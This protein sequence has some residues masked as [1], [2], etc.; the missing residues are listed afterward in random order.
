MKTM[1]RVFTAGDSTEAL[2][3][4]MEKWTKEQEG[5]GVILDYAKEAVPG[6][7]ITKEKLDLIQSVFEDCMSI[8]GQYSSSAG[9]QLAVKV[10]GVASIDLLKKF[11]KAQHRIYNVFSEGYGDLNQTLTAGEVR[12]SGLEC[13]YI[14]LCVLFSLLGISHLKVKLV[15][16]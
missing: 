13:V 16:R 15:W 10:T 7:K 8:S 2:V 3:P 14:C 4:F 5:V 1:G 11:T 6:E 9:N 12:K